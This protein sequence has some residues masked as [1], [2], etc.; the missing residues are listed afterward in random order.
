M[1]ATGSFPVTFEISVSQVEAGKTKP[2]DQFTGEYK[3]SNFNFP[4]T[5]NLKKEFRFQ[6]VL[7]N[8]E[9]KWIGT[10]CKNTVFGKILNRALTC[11]INLNILTVTFP[12]FADTLP[13]DFEIKV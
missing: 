5:I 6:I 13:T 3:F 4:D 1:L 2:S 10:V 11:K 9:F 8:S 12:G 7:K